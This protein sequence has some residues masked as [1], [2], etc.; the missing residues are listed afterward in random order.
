M[1]DLLIGI[2]RRY[3]MLLI[4]DKDFNSAWSRAVRGVLR[5]GKNITIGSIEEPK[6]IRDVTAVIELT[7]NAIKQIENREIHPQ[8]P[9]KYVDQYCDKFTYEFQRKYLN[10][11]DETLK[12]T[13]TYFDRLVNY[14][15]RGWGKI[16]QLKGLYN[17]LKIQIETNI[18]SNRCQATTWRPDIDLGSESPP[19]F[20]DETEILT[21]NG[22]KYFKDVTYDDK[23]ASLLEDKLVYQ[24]PTNIISYKYDGKMVLCEGTSLNF[25]VTPNHNMYVST[26]KHNTFE[27]IKADN[28]PKECYFKSHA[29]W[30]GIE[31]DSILIGDKTIKMDAFLK[32]LAIYLADG[33][34][35][36][37]H[38]TKDSKFGKGTK[39]RLRITQ[40]NN[41]DEYRKIINNLHIDYNVLE[42]N[43]NHSNGCIHFIINNRSLV[44]Y[45]SQFGKSHNKYIPRWIMNLSSRQIGIFLSTATFGDSSR[46]GRTIRYN[47]TSKQLADGLQ[48]LIL[49][50]GFKG[51]CNI[52]K[53]NN[54]EYYEVKM[55]HY[56]NGLHL[57]RDRMIQMVDYSGVVS[58]VEVPN[59]IIYVRRN[60]NSMWCGNCLQRIW[61]RYL[62]NN[63]VEVHMNWRSR[64]LYTA[65]QA[66][67]VAIIDMLNREV[68][69]P[70]NCR[71]VRLV[72]FIDSLHIYDSDYAAAQGVKLV[73]VNPQE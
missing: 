56:N 67:I 27:L 59:H 40:K 17:C 39:Y 69:R 31:H 9:F 35:T 61:I 38:N 60:G 20:D 68:I 48:E 37:Y 14:K 36:I 24:H 71:I 5:E 30:D 46:R 25:K 26:W 2:N 12:F 52:W 64:D 32:F 66:N 23:I 63:E 33:S 6:P 47:T 7:G 49:K 58:C 45:V 43:D 51:S 22:W 34:F 65:W 10:A 72:E 16:D 62:G 42:E 21:L 53:R 55:A 50:S 44:E 28:L 8:F 54:V 15:S 11:E 41:K 57:H 70:N 13:Y 73:S 1:V 4:T 18:P 19:C 3:K 29:T